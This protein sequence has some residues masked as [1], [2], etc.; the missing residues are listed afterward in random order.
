MT[1][2]NER[3]LLSIAALAE[4][5]LEEKDGVLS[6]IRL[7]DRYEITVQD[8]EAP[9]KMPAIPLSLAGLIA[10]KGPAVK[11][12]YKLKVHL[13]GSQGQRIEGVEPTFEL[14][15]GGERNITNAIMRFNIGFQNE[16]RYWFH[17]L[18]NDE[19]VTRM[20]L[21]IIYKRAVATEQSG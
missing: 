2:N 15:F 11:G 4:N 10:F 14:S 18:L 16:G 12:T 6:M 3:P 1:D 9:E 19:L 7:V 21:D 20:P 5:V 8:P 17:V 13:Y